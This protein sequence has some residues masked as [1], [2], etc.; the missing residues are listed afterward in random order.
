MRHLP[1]HVKFVS[2][3]HVIKSSIVLNVADAIVTCLGTAGVEM[4]ALRGIPSI[5]ASD[6][7]YDGLGFTVKPKT[8]K[9]YF[10]LLATIN[11]KA[12]SPEQQLRAKCCYLYLYKYCMMPF[13]AGPALTVEEIS[14]N[15]KKLT[16]SFW[17]RVV[18]AYAEKND[19]I[20]S[21]F[22]EY[23]AEIKKKDF[24]KLVR[25]PFNLNVVPGSFMELFVNL[26]D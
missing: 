20:Y 25:M 17:E 5:V 19:L 1:S 16:D 7:F 9:E 18:K 12:L 22:N 10:D 6:T 13:S 23:T 24:K 26:K 11:P 15:S 21:Q 14:I 8:K 2:Q 4:P 3:G